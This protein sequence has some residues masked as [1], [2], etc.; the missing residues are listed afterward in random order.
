MAFVDEIK[1][2]LKAG[3]GGDGIVSWLSM[4]GKPL[5]GPAGGNG[6]RGADVYIRGS[7]DISLLS[8]YTHLTSIEAP[9]GK[10]GRRNKEEGKNGDTMFFALPVGSVV[11]DA[12]R[13][14][15]YQV[16]SEGEEIKILEGGKGGFGN[17]FFKSSRNTTPKESTSGVP[18]EGGVFEIELQLIVDLGFVGLPNVGKSSLLRTLTNAKPKVGDYHFTTLEPSVGDFYGFI[19]ADIPGLIR[20]A[21][22]GK[23]LG[24][25]FLRHIRRT[26]AILHCVSATS[27]DVLKDYKDIRSELE[28]Y[29]ESFTDKKE[30]ILLTQSDMVTDE[31]VE[32][33]KKELET[34]GSEIQVIS[35]LDDELIKKLSGFLSTFLEA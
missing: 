29:D 4:R 23:G 11:R 25:K 30:I 33:K 34:L 7:R 35:I 19:L 26:K 32:K 24:H 20:G 14:K 12:D 10:D 5:G 21:A 31:E 15:V 2:N 17:H 16:L 28:E 3:D 8:D 22:S 13:D 1:L 6:G 18:G 27:E 9:N